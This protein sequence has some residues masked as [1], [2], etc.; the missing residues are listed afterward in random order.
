MRV[1]TFQD[2]EVFA[3]LQ[4][5]GVV[6]ADPGFNV[7][8]VDHEHIRSSYE[9]I[10][11]K[12]RVC[13][14]G[15]HQPWPFWGWVC[16]DDLNMADYFGQV[17]L[18]LEIPDSRVMV[19]D[20]TGWHHVLNRFPLTYYDGED[21][22]MEVSWNRIFDVDVTTRCRRNIDNKTDSNWVETVG[23]TLQ[24]TFFDLRAE[25]IISSQLIA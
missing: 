16:A 25:Y 9:W 5:D 23:L 3:V 24:A 14:L 7:H 1:W 18:E 17:L 4:R 13:L 2:P 8:D 21:I 6:M 15:P 10:V 20:Y 11:A 12:M 22:D 19:S